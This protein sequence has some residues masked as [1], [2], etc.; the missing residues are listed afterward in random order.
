MSTPVYATCLVSQ[1]KYDSVLWRALAVYNSG[2]AADS[3][4]NCK[5]A[6]VQSGLARA[7]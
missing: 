5:H 7:E 2:P 1:I 3:E 4:L 6:L